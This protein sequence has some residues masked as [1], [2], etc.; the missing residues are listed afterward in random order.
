MFRVEPN[1]PSP[2]LS[3]PALRD[4]PSGYAILP[5]GEQTVVSRTRLTEPGDPG[6]PGNP[7]EVSRTTGDAD[8]A[9]DHGVSTWLRLS[10]ATNLDFSAGYTRSTRYGL[11]TV[12]FGLGWRT[13]NFQI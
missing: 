10:P 2:G 8:L 1:G 3:V 13:P 7:F 4:M 5:A 9:R 6:Q 12:F 11:D